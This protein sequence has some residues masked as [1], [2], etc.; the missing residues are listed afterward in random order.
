MPIIHSADRQFM[1]RLVGGL[2]LG[3]NLSQLIDTDLAIGQTQAQTIATVTAR[4]AKLHVAERNILP[5]IVASLR[6]IASFDGTYFG[7]ALAAKPTM[8]ALAPLG[9]VGSLAF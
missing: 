4:A 8:R 5:R 1:T 6:L 3:I 9:A 2:N 7:G